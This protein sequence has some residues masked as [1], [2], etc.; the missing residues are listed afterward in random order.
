[1]LWLEDVAQMLWLE[2]VL[3]YEQIFN[4][5]IRFKL[6]DQDVYI[7]FELETC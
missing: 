3:A 5:S 7:S 1:M 6:I 4:V 2:D